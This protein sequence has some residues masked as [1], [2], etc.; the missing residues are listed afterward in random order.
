MRRRSFV[1]GRSA[2][3]L[4]LLGLAVLALFATRPA[5]V[6]AV[7]WPSGVRHA[8]SASPFAAARAAALPELERRAADPP[9]DCV[10]LAPLIV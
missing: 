4:R 5:G 2:S 3:R 6:A 8:M 7:G 10:R 9:L 1:D